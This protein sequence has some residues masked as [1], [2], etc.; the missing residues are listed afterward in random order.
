MTNTLHVMPVG[1]VVGHEP[2]CA[3]ICGPTPTPVKRDDGSV[4]WVLTHHALDGRGAGHLWAQ[5]PIRQET[6]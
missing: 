2:D 4:G 3:C 1:D 6:T 5:K